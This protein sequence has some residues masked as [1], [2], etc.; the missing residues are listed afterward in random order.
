[1]A[2]NPNTALSNR[3]AIYIGC[4]GSGKTQALKQN[5]IL[6]KAKRVL[7]WDIDH[8]HTAHRFESR[9]DFARALASALRSNKGFKLAYSGADT[10]GN[11][12]W[13]NRLAWA[14]L[15]GNKDTVLVCEELADVSPSPAKAT[16]E[17]GKGLRKGRKYGAVYLLTTQRAT[18]VPKTA[19]NQMA[20]IYVGQ[21]KAGD[22]ARVAKELGLSDTALRALQKLEFYVVTQGVD[23]PK[24]IKITPRK[25]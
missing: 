4:T 15:D 25:K 16:A 13:F 3:H 23:A 10:V 6:K 17:F 2:K 19:Y 5:P 20:T 14:A 1:M 22:I 12:E 11:F 21:Q 7:Y 9:A 18:E 8:D 24:K